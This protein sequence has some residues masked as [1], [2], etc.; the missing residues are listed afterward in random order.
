MPITGTAPVLAHR[1]SASEK[2]RYGSAGLRANHWRLMALI[3]AFSHSAPLILS[4]AAKFSFDSGKS[5]HYVAI[6]A[7]TLCGFLA[8][9]NDFL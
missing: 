3:R 7:R 8:I 9:V 1:V 2:A 4:R 6:R 5:A